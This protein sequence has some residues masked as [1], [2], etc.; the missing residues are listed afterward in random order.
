MFKLMLHEEHPASD[1]GREHDDW[2]VNEQERGEPNGAPCPDERCHDRQV[3]YVHAR[4]FAAPIGRDAER[5][6]LP[7]GKQQG[8]TNTKQKQRMAINSILQA[9]KIRPA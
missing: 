3:R 7:K 6:A 2:N 8:W 1:R 4:A 5:K 9:A